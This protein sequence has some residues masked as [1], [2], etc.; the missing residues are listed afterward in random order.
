MT[1]LPDTRSASEQR[2]NEDGHCAAFGKYEEQAQHKQRK[3]NREQP[4]FFLLCHKAPEVFE[5]FHCHATY[6]SVGS[7]ATGDFTYK[8]L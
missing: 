6:L 7:I 2:I 8:D 5:E 3:K 1:A 4:P